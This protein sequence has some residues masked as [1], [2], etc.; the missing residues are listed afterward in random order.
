[1]STSATYAKRKQWGRCVD[2]GRQPP[3][4]GLTQCVN[5]ARISNAQTA[6]Y[7]QTH[8]HQIQQKSAAI[9]E[10]IWNAPGPNQLACCGRFYPITALPFIT[11]CCG[12]VFFGRRE[13]A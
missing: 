2:C 9:R 3:R 13:E 8:R 10:A 11:P 4:S 5:C 12:R 1:M 6:R 7:R